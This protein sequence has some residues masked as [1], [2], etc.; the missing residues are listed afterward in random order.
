MREIVLGR[1]ETIVRLLAS[2]ANRHGLI[3]GATGTGKTVSLKVLAEGLSDRGVPS[4]IVDVKGDLSG[5]GARGEMNPKIEERLS[6]LGLSDFQFDSY[7]LEFWDLFEEEGLPVRTSI[8][9]MGPLLLSKLLNLNEVQSG[10]LSIAFKLADDM[11]MLLLDIKDLRAM[12]N[13]I[14][15]KAA[16]YRMSYGNISP[17]TV[18]AILR[19]LLI[20]EEEGG[21]EFFSEPCL[22]I[23][24]LMQRDRSGKGVI[25][26]LNAK[27]LYLKPALYSTLL[28]W[29]LSEVFEEFEEV[30]DLPQPK[31]VLFFDEAHL[32][33]KDIPKVLLTQV[34]QVVRLIRSKGIGVYFISQSPS[35][36]PDSV[37]SQLGNKVQHAL[38]AYTPNEIKALRTIAGSFRENPAFKTEEVLTE[39]EIGEAL[40]SFIDEK[41]APGVVERVLVSP[42]RSKMGSLPR[43]EMER[44]LDYSYFKTKYANKVDR[45]SAYE[46]LDAR[47]AEVEA[48]KEEDRREKEEEKERARAEARARREREKQAEKSEKE[49]QRELERQ[50]K[51]REKEAE[52]QAKEREKAAKQQK[53]L[54]DKVTGS[55][56]SSFSRQVGSSL[57][58]GLMGT[59]KKR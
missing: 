24:D 8:S 5:L 47:A 34:E 48:K 44:L 20:L 26:I 3:T 25:N 2:M 18:G 22:D 29:L 46:L 58:R 35:D 13:H 57:A 51:A 9:E 53:Q 59:F 7:P 38:R 32:I 19:Q 37:L 11:N 52:R 40:V 1:G 23:R 31:L 36:L 33:F 10:V 16:E 45:E 17:A 39:L 56:V 14:A 4:F 28:L 27:K 41:G 6:A 30:G 21:N 55:F 42:P 15:D 54:F 12:L 49:R 50:E 43:E